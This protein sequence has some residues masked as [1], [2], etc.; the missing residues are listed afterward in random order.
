MG[1]E[2][3]I[4]L[5]Y[6]AGDN[7]VISNDKGWV[8]TFSKCLRMM[9]VQTNAY[10]E[11]HLQ[12]LADDETGEIEEDSILIALLSP[13]FILSGE[14][15]DRL[16][17]FI[18]KTEEAKLSSK[19]FKVFK[20]PLDQ[21]DVPDAI[22]S[23]PS[24]E[25]YHNDLEE[26]DK[27]LFD[28]FSKEAEGSFWMK[29]I[30]LSF[31]I[32]E[33]NRSGVKRAADLNTDQ[34][35]NAVYLAN[36]G[37]DLTGARSIIK[38]ELIRHGF[39][40]FP[41]TQRDGR[42]QEVQ[43]DTL[44]ELKLCAYSI[45]LLGA[46]YGSLVKGS[47]LSLMDLENDLAS[48]QAAENPAFKRLIWISPNL[49]R[50]SEKQK[51]FIQNIKRDKQ[52]SVGA[53]ILQTSLEDFKNTLWDEL[54]DQKWVKDNLQNQKRDLPRLYLIYAPSDVQ[55]AKE[56]KSKLEKFEVE[57]L[58]MPLQGSLMDLR[59]IHV[60]NLRDMDGAIVLQDHVND[61]WV[62]M[63]LLDLL[64]APGFGRNYPLLGRLML[65]SSETNSRK[66]FEQRY[67]IKTTDLYNDEELKEFVD[68]LKTSFQKSTINKEEQGT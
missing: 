2:L 68:S 19:V 53:E 59:A 44:A 51:T 58:E 67:H 64:K 22:K 36:T 62:H 57:L 9:L 37:Q 41:K 66:A 13:D 18:S 47:E 50:A 54:L 15:L 42:L 45:H 35:G 60:N 6:S 20:N 26:G 29:L 56:L 7:N 40:V 16:E 27:V 61:Q 30:D 17:A 65:S 21:I 39:D 31:E 55:K 63:K 32:L 8:D 34:Q 28:F 5:L 3:H 38:R 4:T 11:I 46:S 52:A 49:K 24:Y 33:Q 1:Q 48:K 25:L 12:L 10:D 14:C 23:L 43:R